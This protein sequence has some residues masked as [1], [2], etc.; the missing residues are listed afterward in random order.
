MSCRVSRRSDVCDAGIANMP[1]TGPPGTTG[2][3]SRSRS[4]CGRLELRMGT[5]FGTLVTKARQSRRNQTET[6]PPTL[7]TVTRSPIT[8]F[9]V[10]AI[11]SS[12]CS[13]VGT[14]VSPPPPD[15]TCRL[16]KIDDDVVPSRQI[17]ETNRETHH[18]T[19]LHRSTVVLPDGVIRRG[20]VIRAGRVAAPANRRGGPRPV[21]RRGRR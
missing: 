5:K 6:R 4:R 13:A 15:C 21:G 19:S 3:T 12:A 2:R 10:R 16:A 1:P 17:A 8:R 11:T 20:H 14:M 9:S 18:A 7:R